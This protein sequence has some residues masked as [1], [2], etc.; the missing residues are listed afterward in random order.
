MKKIKIL[1]SLMALFTFSLAF[2]SCSSDDE[3]NND[4]SP[5][6]VKDGVKYNIQGSEEF[7]SIEFTPN[8]EYIVTRK[9]P[10]K[11][12]GDITLADLYVHGK[13]TV[14]DGG[15]RLDGFGTV[16]IDQDLAS[17][18]ITIISEGYTHEVNATVAPKK[19][20]DDMS[21]A[22]CRH[23]RFSKSHFALRVNNNV[24]VN[25]DIDG[26][27]FS[28]WYR[29]DKV[30]DYDT[31]NERFN[32]KCKDLLLT[33]YGTFAVTYADDF[34]NVGT[35]TWENKGGNIIGCDWGFNSFRD[36]HFNGSMSTELVKGSTDAEDQLVI[37]KQINLHNPYF[38]VISEFTY[39]L[40]PR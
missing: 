37:T 9:A 32:S 8:G 1:L 16:A 5:N 6:L 19:L 18:K 27:D 24:I 34:I 30:K 2:V 35:W 38:L 15:Y 12:S 17:A 13:F 14:I 40:V 11:N 39:T 7:S 3:K 25:F 26:C 10:A 31:D 36:D 20:S 22:F 28:K 33:E 21:R 23:W 29:N 4:S